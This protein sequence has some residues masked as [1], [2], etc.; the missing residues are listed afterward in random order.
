MA[1][2]KGA[3]TPTPEEV[4]KTAKSYVRQSSYGHVNIFTKW[5]FGDNTYA[6]YC[7][8]FV[9]YVLAKCG[10]KTLEAG[11]ANKAYC[12]SVWS[13]AKKKGIAVSRNAT[14]KMGWLVLFDWNDDAVCDHIGFVIKDNGNGTVTTV[15]GNT[16]NTSNG[17]GGCVQVRVRSKSVIRGFVKLQYSEVEWPVYI[18]I[19]KVLIN[20]KS[21]SCRDA[22]TKS[23]RQN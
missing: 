13:W 6:Q 4:I 15:E 23:S 1:T 10:G 22:S 7:A 14:A 21:R 16:S 20:P 3:V 2:A 17:N 11:C 19:S 8:I 18:S 5:Y 9:Y 12:P